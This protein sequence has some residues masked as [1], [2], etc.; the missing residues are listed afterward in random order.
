MNF[1]VESGELSLDF[2]DFKGESPRDAGIEALKCWHAAEERIHL[3]GLLTV[4]QLGP[5]GGVQKERMFSTSSLLEEL[6]LKFIAT[7]GAV[8]TMPQPRPKILA[9][10]QV[11]GSKWLALKRLRY[12]WEGEGEKTWE[13]VTRPTRKGQ[14]DAVVIVPFLKNPNRLVVIGEFRLPLNDY[15]IALPAGLI[16]GNESAEDA[17]RRE[18][19]EE[20][21]LDISK[22]LAVSPPLYSSAGLTDENVVMVFCECTGEVTSV[23]NAEERIEVFAIDLKGVESILD[24]PPCSMSARLWPLLQMMRMQGHVGWSQK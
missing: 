22:V 4:K 21:G 23:S 11:A 18:L 14:S 12:Q 16:D 1:R 17:A 5:R 10:E 9:A 3:C 7:E 19:K 15:E 13:F 2:K 24:E 20:T 6:G 8:I